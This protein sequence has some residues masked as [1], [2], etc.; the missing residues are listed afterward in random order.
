MGAG[1]LPQW[2][3]GLIALAEN[4]HD[5]SRLPV[6]P[7]PG[8]MTPFSDLKDHQTCHVYILHDAI[9]KLY[10]YKTNHYLKDIKSFSFREEK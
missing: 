3:G 10:K 1:E 5:G 9:I 2:L 7:V 6:T 4:S 8:D